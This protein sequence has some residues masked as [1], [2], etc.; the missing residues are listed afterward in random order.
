MTK[1][2]LAAQLETILRGH[3]SAAPRATADK[4]R[5]LWLQA[6][7]KSIDVI[8]AGLREQQETMAFRFLCSD[9]LVRESAS[10]RARE[11]T[12]ICPWHN[13]SGATTG[14]KGGSSP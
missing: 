9:R 4:L 8:K 5:D 11:S 2:E 12:T 14:V 7:P 10:W 3:D 1:Q 6:D 13:C